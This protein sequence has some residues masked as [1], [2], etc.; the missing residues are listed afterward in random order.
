MEESGNRLLIITWDCWNRS[1]KFLRCS[2]CTQKVSE[3]LVSKSLVSIVGLAGLMVIWWSL[4]FPICFIG[5]LPVEETCLAYNHLLVLLDAL[6]N[7]KNLRISCRW[8][9]IVSLLHPV[10][11]QISLVS[12]FHLDK[13]KRG[14]LFPNTVDIRQLWFSNEK[15]SPEHCINFH[16]HGPRKQSETIV[17]IYGNPHNTR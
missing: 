15:P 5:L 6:I 17:F 2:T 12:R 11:H 9:E 10:L 13:I 7:H 14:M 16:S 1:P 3:S 4:S 8:L